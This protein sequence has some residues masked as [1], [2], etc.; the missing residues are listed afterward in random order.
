MVTRRR[1]PRAHDCGRPGQR[2]H[3]HHLCPVL[4]P[5]PAP[6]APAPGAGRH[7]PGT[8]LP[9]LRVAHR[10]PGRRPRPTALPGRRHRHHGRGLRLR[11]HDPGPG[12]ARARA[13]RG[14]LRT[15]GRRRGG[16]GGRGSPPLRRGRGRRCRG[17]SPLPARRSP[18]RGGGPRR[19]G[20]GR[21]SGRGRPEPAVCGRGRPLSRPQRLRRPDDAGGRVPPAQ[22]SGAG[23]GGAGRGPRRDR[24]PP[25]PPGTVGSPRGDAP[26]RRLLGGCRQA[27]GG[28]APATPS[29]CPDSVGCRGQQRAWVRR[30][31]PGR[32][33]P[34]FGRRRRRGAGRGGLHGGAGGGGPVLRPRPGIR[35]GCGAW[36]R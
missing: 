3:V 16:A 29:A 27:V 4:D 6:G 5:H 11:R 30:D 36:W 20:R 28:P 21:R 14:A 13:R 32:T 2:L 19:H 26:G 23:H 17:R 35:L 25:G 15:A 31:H 22:R 33:P 7:R 34:A 9:P 10:R 12:C 24:R 8:L 1:L 18:G